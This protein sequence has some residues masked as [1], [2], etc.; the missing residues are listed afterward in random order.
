MA[1]HGPVG[2]GMPAAG[3]PALRAQHA[4]YLMAQLTAVRHRHALHERRQGR[5]RRRTGRADHARHREPADA[6]GHARRRLVRAGH[7]LGDREARRSSPRCWRL[8]WSA[9]VTPPRRRAPSSIRRAPLRPPPSLPPLQRRGARRGR[10]A[11]YPRR[12]Q[13]QQ[14]GADTGTART[15]ASSHSSAS[16]PFSCGRAARGQMG[17]RHQLQGARTRAAHGRGARA[18]SRSS[19]CSGTAARTAMRSIRRIEHWRKNK[20]PYIE[21]VR[22]PVHVGRAAPRPCAPVL[23]AAGARAAR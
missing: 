23:H 2:R 12:P 13:T 19:N 8:C 5:Q 18:R 7:A 6:G 20:A 21:F 16:R 4:V 17:G 22:V 1:C 15:A 3:Y 9:A 11:M 14:E 10:P